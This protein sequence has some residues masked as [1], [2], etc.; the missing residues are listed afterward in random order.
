L[1]TVF[2]AQMLRY[3][4]ERD[5][6]S[7]TSLHG[8]FA[9]SPQKNGPVLSGA[10]RGSL[11]ANATIPRG[12][13]N[14]L[15]ADVPV[16][17]ADPKL[18][19]AFANALVGFKLEVPDIDISRTADSTAVRISKPISL[20]ASNGGQAEISAQANRP[21]SQIASDAFEGGFNASAHGGGL[22]EVA[23]QVSSY[24]V[25]AKGRGMTFDASAALQ[26]KLDYGPFK[27]VKV[28]ANGTATQRNGVLS[29]ALQRCGDLS[30]A[31]YG[32][33][34]L[35]QV[36]N[37][38]TQICAD[39]G[40]PLLQ[41]DNAGWRLAAAWSRARGKLEQAQSTIDAADGRIALN[42]DGSGLKGG[43][44]D[45]STALLTDAQAMARYR[46]VTA[47]GVMT[48][49]RQ[50]WSGMFQ[51]TGHQRKLAAVQVRHA[52]DDG[53]GS[54]TIEASDITFDPMF[55]PTDISPLLTS[56]G[57]RVR[58]HASF[59]GSA[60]WNT[61]TM[62]TG[63]TLHIVD[64]DVQTPLGMARGI[65]GDL[66]LTSLVPVTFAPSQTITVNRIDWP[67]PAE[68]ISARFSL[69]PERIQ[70][71][72][73]SAS[74]AGGR[75]SLDPMSYSFAPGATTSGTLRFE[76]IDLAPVIVAAGLADK[77]KVTSRIGGVVPFTMGPDGLRFANGHI[78]AESPGRL[79]IPRTALTSAVGTGANGQ[80]QPN[81]VQDFAYQALEN[82][83]FTELNGDVNSRP[84]GRLGV[85]FH[86]KG[87]HDPAMSTETRVGVVELL[88]GRAFDKPL[89]L[90]K[91]TPIDL[92]LDT[93]LNLD[94]LLASY[95]G[96]EP[97]MNAASK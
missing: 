44:L 22:P 25:N 11:M 26:A 7:L 56:L 80:A 92:T 10:L 29:L 76:H 88:Q 34:A 18:A 82:L 91:G 39:A 21:I 63:G 75:L 62:E 67:V 97:R 77:V 94:E 68:Q 1:R 69:T 60:A 65:R 95:F 17:G 15:A 32:A 33:G 3:Q 74:V 81:A 96:N 38:E 19:E 89:P 42:G 52:M 78:A 28:S 73:V 93:S 4:L 72:A 45:V 61:K 30:V 86:I 48:L 55:Q 59:S 51:L 70:L 66:A 47:T 5:A 6:I 31:S 43:R 46:P 20:A 24:R 37:A 84:M 83:S 71:E 27:G 87:E 54:A 50:E 9:G 14:A 58:G 16:A 90:P 57:T 40:A 8:V 79:S 13:A 36:T 12:L 35:N 64:D 2:D 85:L 41:A 53:V 23:L 49:S